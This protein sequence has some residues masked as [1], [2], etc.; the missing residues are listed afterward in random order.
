MGNM[1]IIRNAVEKFYDRNARYSLPMEILRNPES[2]EHV[3]SIGTSIMAHYWG[4]INYSPG[5]FVKNFLANDLE[6]TIASADD[7]NIHALQFFAKLKY[8][9]PK[10]NLGLNLESNENNQK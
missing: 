3:I 8:N 2:C 7:V 1:E 5:S 10:P 4:V 6:A 9:T